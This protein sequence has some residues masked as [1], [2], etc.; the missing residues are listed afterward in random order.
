MDLGTLGAG[1]GAGITVL[2]AG[3]GI[4]RLAAAALEAL[5]RQPEIAGDARTTM[6]IAAA[7]IEGVALFSCVICMLLVVMK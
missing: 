5:A 7:L 1:L 2:G 3:L 4:G 6:I